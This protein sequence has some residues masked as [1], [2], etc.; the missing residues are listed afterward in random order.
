MKPLDTRRMWSV[1]ASLM[2]DLHMEVGLSPADIAGI[3]DH[4]M[5]SIIGPQI[6]SCRECS[7]RFT[8][9]ILQRH[10]S[11]ICATPPSPPLL[12]HGDLKEKKLNCTTHI[13]NSQRRRTY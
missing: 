8:S 7:S 5:A 10:Q 1:V 4:Q 13:S 6:M 9:I 11:S 2:I 12:Y 3:D